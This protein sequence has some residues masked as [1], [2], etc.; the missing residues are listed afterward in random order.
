[1]DDFYLRLA[2]VKAVYARNDLLDFQI[3]V[4]SVDY[5]ILQRVF[6]VLV[7]HEI[8]R[9]AFVQE[10][11]AIFEDDLNGVLGLLAQK[12]FWKFNIVINISDVSR[13]QSLP[14]DHHKLDS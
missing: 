9:K 11:V 10:G 8:S 1:V 7:D 14:V 2:V 6:I 4:G 5:L 13:M 12:L 3:S